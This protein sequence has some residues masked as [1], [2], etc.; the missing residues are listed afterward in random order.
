MTLIENGEVIPITHLF[1]QD[2][3]PVG[4]WEEAYTFVAGPTPD[5][6]WLSARCEDFSVHRAH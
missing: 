3:E 5:G 2:G 1:D 6:K 4:T